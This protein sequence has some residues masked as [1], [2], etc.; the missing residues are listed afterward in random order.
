VTAPI[1]VAAFEPFDGRARNRSWETVRR[2]PQRPGLEKIQ[3]SVDLTR[4]QQALAPLLQRRPRAILLLGESPAPTTCVEQVAI[5]VFDVDRSPARQRATPLT[6]VR[7][8][9]ALA[10]QASWDARALA[11]RLNGAGI[12]AVA[13]FHAGTFAC[14]AALYLA[15]DAAVTP[16]VGFLHVPY[17]RWPFG[18]A[19]SK[20]VQAAEL[21]L[22]TLLAEPDGTR[23]AP[24]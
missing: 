23:S 13:S 4:L 3:L 6:P 8:G 9:G 22:A 16:A 20:L 21:S 7:A 14:N 24:A 5:N 17:R 10:L 2:M 19:L 15:L 1:I 18:L 12:P 11:G